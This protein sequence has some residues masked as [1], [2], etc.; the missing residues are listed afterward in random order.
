MPKD[1]GTKPY[2]E[3]KDYYE[4]QGIQTIIYNE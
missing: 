4:S 3:I 1:N 2:L